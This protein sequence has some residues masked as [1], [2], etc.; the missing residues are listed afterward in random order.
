MGVCIPVRF[1]PNEFISALLFK[2]TVAMAKIRYAVKN[3]SDM[4][5]P[6][7]HN[8]VAAYFQTRA[9]AKEEDP[10][11]IRVISLERIAQLRQENRVPES[12]SDVDFLF[13]D[14]SMQHLLRVADAT[15][16]FSYTTMDEQTA[17]SSEQ[18]RVEFPAGAFDAEAGG[19]VSATNV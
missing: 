6:G 18:Q 1:A 4:G 17:N 2:P 9:G 16:T 19:S 14:P 3:F 8:A 7:E 5:P 15:L 11:P 10:K 13:G 12:V